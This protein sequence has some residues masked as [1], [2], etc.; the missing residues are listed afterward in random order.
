MLQG[1][2]KDD[3]PVPVGT[4]PLVER[5]VVNDTTG[6]AYP[7]DEYG[8]R[9]RRSARPKEIPPDTWNTFSANVN[10]EIREYFDKKRTAVENDADII[11]SLVA[12]FD[13]RFEKAVSGY[14]SNDAEEIEAHVASPA[15]VTTT[16][17]KRKKDSKRI[18][19]ISAM[20]C[21]TQVDTMH[22]P[23]TPSWVARPVGKQEIASEPTAQA[24]I[25]KEWSNLRL[26]KVWDDSVV[27]EWSDVMH[28]ARRKGGI[29]HLGRLFGICVEKG[30][31]LAVG[32]PRR[33]Y[34][35]RVV[36][37]GNNVVDQ[38]WE[39]ALFQDLGSCP[40]TME[41]GK[42]VDA[43]GCFPGHIVQQSVAEQAYV[44]ADLK[45]SETWV[46]LPEDA[47]PPG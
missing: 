42:A 7:V 14:A 5:N 16:K 21:Q 41:A 3:I 28:D 35:Y 13:E 19:I 9:I 43:H 17:N 32:D 29:T 44:Q 11:D 24:A 46:L 20:P 4:I 36:F 30:S 1:T 25:K 40:A 45:G 8:H 26:R 39:V 12:Q 6:R 33:K 10:A 15:I 27:R 31:E 34:K 18:T 23:K 22:R 38:N 37:Q 47:W 2:P